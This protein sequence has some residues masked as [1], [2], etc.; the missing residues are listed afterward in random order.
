M[1]DLRGNINGEKSFLKNLFFAGFH[2]AMRQ[3]ILYHFAF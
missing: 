2:L 3:G 1:H